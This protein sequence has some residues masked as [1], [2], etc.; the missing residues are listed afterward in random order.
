[1]EVCES[2]VSQVKGRSTAERVYRLLSLH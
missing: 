1:V 2:S